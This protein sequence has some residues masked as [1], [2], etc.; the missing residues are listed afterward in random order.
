MPVFDFSQPEG[1]RLR[2]E[3]IENKFDSIKFLM[4][5]YATNVYTEELYNF[6]NLTYGSLGMKEDIIEKNMWF[7]RHYPNSY[8]LN[9]IVYR[10]MHAVYHFRNGD[11]DVNVLL[12][13]LISSDPETLAAK[14]AKQLKTNKKYQR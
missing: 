13:E 8:F 6:Y 4:D 2:T 1:Q 9:D 7:I 11:T 3:W 10:T 12:N 14:I 5:N